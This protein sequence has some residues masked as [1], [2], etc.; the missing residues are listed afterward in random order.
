VMAIRKSKVIELGGIKYKVMSNDLKE[1]DIISILR[2]NAAHVQIIIN[3]LETIKMII[4]VIGGIDLK[5]KPCEDK[6]ISI[7][8]SNDIDQFKEG[9]NSIES[10]R[11][12]LAKR[13]SKII[14]Q[15]KKI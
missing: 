13:K 3:Q 9:I 12:F 5:G 11:K 7:G 8:I 4:S 14:E 10:V 1:D 2:R 15:I 6:L